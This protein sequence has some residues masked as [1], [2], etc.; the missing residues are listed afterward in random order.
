MSNAD[1]KSDRIRDITPLENFI[2]L[3]KISDV[4]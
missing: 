3:V 4:I 1:F 2:T